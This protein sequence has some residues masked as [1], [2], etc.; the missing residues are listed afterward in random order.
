MIKKTIMGVIFFGLIL[1]FSFPAAAS[2][3][4]TCTISRV[5]VSATSGNGY[6]AL[7]WVSGGTSWTGTRTFTF[8]P[9]HVN[10]SLAVALAAQS[11]GAQVYV[12]LAD[13][14]SGSLVYV[15]YVMND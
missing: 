7:N 5:G 1:F 8:I 15:I 4:S 10:T 9:D 3:W 13:T 12:Q 11:N 14:S 6:I 2:Q